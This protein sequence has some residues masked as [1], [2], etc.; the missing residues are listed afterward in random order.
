MHDPTLAHSF[1]HPL[2]N[3]VL[4]YSSLAPAL[5]LSLDLIMKLLAE[6][7]ELRGDCAAFGR[8]RCLFLLL[9]AVLE[10]VCVLLEALTARA[11]HSLHRHL[12]P[13]ITEKELI[14]KQPR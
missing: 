14:P 13:W 10:K 2:V 3:Q 9:K 4:R 1:Y 12:A 5:K 11:V 6:K 7:D 8:G